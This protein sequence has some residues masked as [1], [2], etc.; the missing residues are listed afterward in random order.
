MNLAAPNHQ[1]WLQS[2]VQQF[3]KTCNWEDEPIAVQELRFASLLDDHTALSLNLNVSQFFAAINWDG[4]TLATPS[5]IVEAPAPIAL[6]ADGTFTL[7][8]LSDLF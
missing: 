4:T 5:P 3:F 1:A 2:S 8:E 7:S 6:D